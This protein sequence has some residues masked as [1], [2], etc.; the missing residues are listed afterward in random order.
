M[1]FV[2]TAAGSAASIKVPQG[3]RRLWGMT[4]LG[5]LAMATMGVCGAGAVAQDTRTVSEPSIPGICII[6]KAA[7]IAPR[8]ITPQDEMWVDTPRIQAAIDH[9]QR[10]QA[11]ELSRDGDARAF[12]SGTLHLHAGVTLLIDKDVTLYGSRNPRDYDIRRGSCGTVDD[13]DKDGCYALIEADHANH[14]GVMGEGVIDGRGGEKLL[15]NGAVQPVSWWMLGEEARMWGHQQVPRLI[16]TDHSNDFTVYE[17]TL[18]NSPGAHVGFRNGDG[19]TVWGIRIDTPRNVMDA[20][21]IDPSSAKDVTVAESYIRSGDD[22]IAI[23]AG[24]KPTRNVSI[25]RNHFYWGDGMAIGSE[26][27][28]GVSSV[29]VSDLTIDGPDDGIRIQSDGLRG[30]VVSGVTYEDVCIRGAKAP[31]TLDSDADAKGGGRVHLPLYRDIV[32]RNVRV[33]GGGKLEIVGAD[34]AHHIDARFDG[35][36]LTD[37]ASQYVLVAKHAEILQGPGPVNFQM[38]GE[39]SRLLGR[40]GA[41]APLASCEAKFVPFPG[42]PVKVEEAAVTPPPAVERART[43]RNQE[44]I[45]LGRPASGSLAAVTAEPASV[46][47]VPAQ[48]QLPPESAVVQVVRHPAPARVLPARRMAAVRRA[49][50]RCRRSHT[51]STRQVRR[52]AV[53][54][55]GSRRRHHR[56]ATKVTTAVES[57]SPY[58][59]AGPELGFQAMSKSR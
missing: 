15:L 33:S 28:G 45:T 5:L 19:L 29:L 49:S 23:Q 4:G 46:A 2:L 6:L 12:L 7:M 17:V 52:R 25:L 57:R 30:G 34:S 11:V 59:A 21:G 13:S 41:D 32:L 36:E 27:H 40:L 51:C 43:G 47:A 55:R 38:L 39:D 35:V 31:I 20:D 18:R 44:I 22:N 16:D 48:P 1:S 37:S 8:G 10:G 54:R 14:A 53:Y 3:R 42:D 50:A 58:A 26:T 24:R 9:C 56:M